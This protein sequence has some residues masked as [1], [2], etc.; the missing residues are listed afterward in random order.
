MQMRES[1]KKMNQK[2]RSRMRVNMEIVIVRNMKM[3]GTAREMFESATWDQS[4]A[5]SDDWCHMKT[6]LGLK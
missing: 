6:G 1:M 5:I 2:N 3:N 4:Q